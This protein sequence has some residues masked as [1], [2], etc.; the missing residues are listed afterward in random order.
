MFVNK[1][2]S[3]MKF[4]FSLFNAFLKKRPYFFFYIIICFIHV[5]I[6]EIP[7]CHRPIA[8]ICADNKYTDIMLHSMKSMNF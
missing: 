4:V 8:H 7:T 2:L 5:L 1:I 3:M 6:V